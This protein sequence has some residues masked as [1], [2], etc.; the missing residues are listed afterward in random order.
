MALRVGAPGWRSEQIG[1]SVSL[2]YIRCLEK[3]Q[4]SNQFSHFNVN[5]VQRETE[6]VVIPIQICIPPSDRAKR[7][8]CFAR[9]RDQLEEPLLKGFS[10]GCTLARRESTTHSKDEDAGVE[11]GLERFRQQ[12]SRGGGTQHKLTSE[13]GDKQGL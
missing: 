4:E 2:G 11:G 9:N 7:R 1:S 12:A 8:C 5:F 13:G 6:R 3:R 10:V